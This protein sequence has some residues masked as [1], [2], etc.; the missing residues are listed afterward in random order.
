MCVEG[1]LERVWKRCGSGVGW[2]SLEGMSPGVDLVW[3]GIEG[4][5]VLNGCGGGVSVSVESVWDGCGMRM[6]RVSKAGTE[7]TGGVELW[8][9]CGRVWNSM[10]GCGLFSFSSST[11]VPSAGKPA[12]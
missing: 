8:N 6:K 9:A 12:F 4:V 10:E 5:R 11:R 7:G 3:N 1:D 2:D